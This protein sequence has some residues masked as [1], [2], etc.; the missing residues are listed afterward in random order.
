MRKAISICIDVELAAEQIYRQFEENSKPG[1]VQQELW[2][3]AADDE[4]EH[5]RI[6]ELAMR[7]V[8]EGA[9]EEVRIDVDVA[10]T[11]RT[12]AREFLLDV[13]AGKLDPASTLK[14]MLTLERAFQQVHAGLSIEFKDQALSQMFAKLGQGDKDHIALL[15][16]QVGQLCR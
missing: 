8:S 10:R 2:R 13:K 9:V 16:D 1:T 15:E 4:R 3:R 11:L 5:A 7:M 14:T 6:L 12:N